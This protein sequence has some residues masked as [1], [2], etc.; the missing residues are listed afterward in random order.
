MPPY[1][2]WKAGTFVQ[3]DPSH[4]QWVVLFA[5]LFSKEGSLESYFNKPTKNV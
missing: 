1:L 5:Q 4:K 3:K 2:T